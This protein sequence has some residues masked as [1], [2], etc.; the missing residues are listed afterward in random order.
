MKDIH[1][2]IGTNGTKLD[3]PASDADAIVTFLRSK[4]TDLET[5]QPTL[6]SANRPVIVSADVHSNIA[7]VIEHIHE[8][9]RTRGIAPQ[10]TP[11]NAGH[12][13][14]EYE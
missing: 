8:W 13:D 10:Y 6:L 11:D 7:D 12:F 2:E 3:L 14:W 4:G 5:P 9:F 1:L